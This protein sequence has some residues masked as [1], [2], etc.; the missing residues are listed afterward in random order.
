MFIFFAHLLADILIPVE[1][2]GK[3]RLCSEFLAHIFKNYKW[4]RFWPISCEKRKNCF[5]HS[6]RRWLKKRFCLTFRVKERF[7]SEFLASFWSKLEMAQVLA[8]FIKSKKKCFRHWLHHWLEKRFCLT[9]RVKTHFGRISWRHF[10]QNW[11]WRRFWPIS[12]NQRKN[13]F[14][15]D[16]ITDFEHMISRNSLKSV[17]SS[18]IS[19]FWKVEL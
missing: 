12:S 5:R 15:I 7:C 9:F 6:L 2:K 14:G 13:A 16:Y 10:V 8:D 4:R 11:K 17:F 1:S 18:E 19:S 3:S